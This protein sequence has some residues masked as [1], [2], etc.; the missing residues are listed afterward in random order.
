M[1]PAPSWN[2]GSVIASARRRARMVPSIEARS[3]HPAITGP[4]LPASATIP[5]QTGMTAY[6][7]PSAFR[8]FRPRQLFCAIRSD[9]TGRICG[10]SL[11]V[12]GDVVGTT[13]DTHSVQAISRGRNQRGWLERRR[14][15]SRTNA[16]P[17]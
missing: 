11:S 16:W 15:G 4:T 1:R 2:R 5:S 10:R 3:A 9:S 17:T 6:V 7:K 8:M 12:K 13:L 14:V